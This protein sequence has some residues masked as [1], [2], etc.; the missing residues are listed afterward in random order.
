ML[1]FFLLKLKVKGK[2]QSEQS[3]R[4]KAERLC[5]ALDFIVERLA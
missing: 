4:I 3:E 1:S 2:A 5:C